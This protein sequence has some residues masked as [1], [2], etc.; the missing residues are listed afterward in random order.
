MPLPKGDRDNEKQILR[1]EDWDAWQKCTCGQ[2]SIHTHAHTHTPYHT[3][4]K[5]TYAHTF[6]T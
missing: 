2:K 5:Q 3:L 1:H 6:V 4:T